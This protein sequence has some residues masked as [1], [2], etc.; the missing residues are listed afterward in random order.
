MTRD[1]AVC[2]MRKA[3]KMERYTDLPAAEY[4]GCGGGH[5]QTANKVD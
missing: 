2:R 1:S 4:G 5:E 3:R